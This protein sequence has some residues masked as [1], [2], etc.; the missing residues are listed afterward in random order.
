MPYGATF[1]TQEETTG[2]Q[3]KLIE[4]VSTVVSKEA[5]TLLRGVEKY[6]TTPMNLIL[7]SSQPHATATSSKTLPKI[8][9]VPEYDSDSDAESEAEDS[10]QARKPSSSPSMDPFRVPASATRGKQTEAGGQVA[11]TETSSQ[12]RKCWSVDDLPIERYE[13]NCRRMG[14]CWGAM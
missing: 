11:R 9:L 12:G 5:E 13:A 4:A 6:A 14:W 8:N 10:M 7:S 1:P 2:V 3:G